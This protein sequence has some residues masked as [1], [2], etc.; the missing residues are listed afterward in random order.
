MLRRCYI[1]KN[2][3]FVILVKTAIDNYWESEEPETDEKHQETEDAK[4]N[5]LQKKLKNYIRL[6][7][8]L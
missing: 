3:F 6:E 4:E 8:Y 1:I 7:S 2:I 5:G